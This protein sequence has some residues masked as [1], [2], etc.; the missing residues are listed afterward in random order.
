MGG[1]LGI[2]P[3]DPNDVIN[4]QTK[5]N[6][7]TAVTQSQLNNVNQ[8]TPWGDISW[9]QTPGLNGVPQWTQNVSLSPDQQKLFNLQL[10]TQ[11]VMAGTASTGANQLKD[12]LRSDI[13]APQYVGY[14]GGQNLNTNAP[15][16]GRIQSSIPGSGDYTADAGRVRDAMLQRM[17]PQ[18]EQDRTRFETQMANQGIRVGSDAYRKAADDLNRGINDQRTSVELAAGQEQTRRQAMDLNAGG[19]TNQA[20]AQ[21]FAQQLAR[22]GFSNDAIQQ[23]FQNR[24]QVTGANNDVASQQFGNTLA[25]RNQKLNEQNA[26]MTGSQ[27]SMPQF[28]GTSQTGVAGVDT[29][30]A[31]KDYYNGMQNLWGG[32]LG[33]IGSAVSGWSDRRL[34]RDI[35]RIG[36]A[37]N[38]LP[39]YAY[40]FGDDPVTFIGFMADEVRELRPDAVQTDPATGFDKVQYA[41]AVL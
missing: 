15:Q 24:M 28:P 18:I 19:F 37:D 10:G 13:P 36:Y 30:G 14:D 3:P 35:R 8:K 16:A 17:N 9:T 32:L 33:G 26:L 11:G 34:K 21:D 41:K 31:R 20:Q 2:L 7:D 22:A 12:M 5:S 4:Q 25:T 29:T 27:V 40:R 38:G 6:T 1:K 23:M 39:I